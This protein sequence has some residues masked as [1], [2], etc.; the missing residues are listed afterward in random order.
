MTAIRCPICD[1]FVD[2]DGE[3][4][5][6]VMLREHL[7]SA[8]D[9]RPSS[10]VLSSKETLPHQPQLWEEMKR[11]SVPPREGGEV[12][13][14]VSESILCPL[15]GDRFFGHDGEDLTQHLIAHFQDAHGIKTRGRSLTLVR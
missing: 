11:G 10:D 5:L 14:D 15:C 4:A 9:L 6:T 7:S 3:A 1:T 13:E 8:H 2:A 12:G